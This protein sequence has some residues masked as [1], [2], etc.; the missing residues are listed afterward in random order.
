M[1]YIAIKI[2]N[3]HYWLWFELKKVKR[4]NGRFIGENG[5]GKNGALISIDIS[6]KLIQGEILSKQLQYN[7]D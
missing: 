3:F 1:E 5:W 4:E 6:E 2:S 7:N